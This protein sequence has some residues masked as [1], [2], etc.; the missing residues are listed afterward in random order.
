MTTPVPLLTIFSFRQANS[1]ISL[2]SLPDQLGV[3][4]DDGPAEV[5]IAAEADPVGDDD[6]G[7]PVA[8]LDPAAVAELVGATQML[9][10]GGVDLCG[11]L[12]GPG[13]DLPEVAGGEEVD[14]QR[15]LLA[16]GGLDVVRREGTAAAALQVVARVD[17]L[18]L[19]RRPLQHLVEVLHHHVARR[20]RRVRR[21]VRPVLRVNPQPPP[22]PLPLQLLLQP[23]PPQQHDLAARLAQCGY[24]WLCEPLPV[25]LE[26][27]VLED[28]GELLVGAFP[29]AFALQREDE[30]LA[31]VVAEEL[32]DLVVQVPEV[33]VAGQ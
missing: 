3:H 19:D 28:P 16:L 15:H 7:A 9:G 10:D 2:Q 5:P 6:A 18:L 11:D 4:A 29:C 22:V 8:V 17:N 23:K 33:F 1:S 31:R 12:L 24:T 21:V 13:V 20:T 14:V 25:V 26:V 30:R 32:Q 27:V